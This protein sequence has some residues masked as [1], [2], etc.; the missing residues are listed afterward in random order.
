MP[1]M[2][3]RTI[4]TTSVAGLLA[5]ALSACGGSDSN[6]A[7]ATVPANVDLE[8]EAGPGLKFGQDSYAAT[9]GTN[10]VA[11]VNRDTQLHSMVFVD[12]DKRTL[13]GELKVGKSGEIDTGEFDLAPGTYQLLCLVPGHDNMKATL[14]VK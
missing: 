12:S 13:P 5:V 8:V 7:P 9:A 6:S 3:R 2:T 14:T 11:L 10:T 4:I 1:G